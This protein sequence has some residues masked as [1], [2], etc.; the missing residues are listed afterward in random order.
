[1]ILH[2][3]YLQENYNVIGIDSSKQQALDD[4]L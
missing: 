1:M 2:Y 3:P 4:D